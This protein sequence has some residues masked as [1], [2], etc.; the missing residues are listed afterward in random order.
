MT[1]SQFDGP[2]KSNV[3]LLPTNVDEYEYEYEK[4]VPSVPFAKSVDI[5]YET[6]DAND[7]TAHNVQM[8]DNILKK[9]NTSGGIAEK[10][11]ELPRAMRGRYNFSGMTIGASTAL[12]SYVLQKNLNQ[13]LIVMH[14]F[15]AE[16]HTK[17]GEISA[18]AFF[19]NAEA[20]KLNLTTA[21][22]QILGPVSSQW[23]EVRQLITYCNLQMMTVIRTQPS[24][25]AVNACARMLRAFGC[26]AEDRGVMALCRMVSHATAMSEIL[27]ALFF[28]TVKQIEADTP[29]IGREKQIEL[30]DQIKELCLDLVDDGR[31]TKYESEDAKSLRSAT[32]PQKF[33]ENLLAFKLLTTCSKPPKS[34]SPEAHND[35]VLMRFAE[36]GLELSEQ[37]D[38]VDRIVNSLQACARMRCNVVIFGSAA[39]HTYMKK[40]IDED[41]ETS[42]W[43]LSL[44]DVMQKWSEGMH[45]QAIEEYTLFTEVEKKPPCADSDYVL[46]CLFSQLPASFAF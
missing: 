11:V 13:F 36:R 38:M 23:A 20:S 15:A 34:E 22:E 6:Q 30:F 19:E 27:P 7:I 12:P 16:L 45:L 21:I 2:G 8:L 39:S 32:N 31:K 9:L 18:E 42:M 43:K 37:F 4:E 44:T 24:A 10:A 14:N 46:A 3:S 5:E 35:A 25:A 17:L 40:H 1:P 26:A 41:P 33:V 28:Y 29:T